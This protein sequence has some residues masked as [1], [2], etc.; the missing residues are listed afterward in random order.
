MNGRRKYKRGGEED[1]K[2]GKQRK[3]KARRGRR[4]TRCASYLR[5]SVL[6]DRIGVFSIYANRSHRRRIITALC[7]VSPPSPPP[8]PPSPHPLPS[9]LHPR[10][11][12]RC[13]GRFLTALPFHSAEICPSSSRLTCLPFLPVRRPPYL[14]TLLTAVEQHSK[15]GAASGHLTIERVEDAADSVGTEASVSGTKA[16]LFFLLPGLSR[17]PTAVAAEQ[18]FD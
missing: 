2:K 15:V 3:T 5:L 6:A 18:I 16:L 4:Q 10:S 13:S 17:S 11:L 7:Q 14:P 9:S 12:I 8:A 1:K